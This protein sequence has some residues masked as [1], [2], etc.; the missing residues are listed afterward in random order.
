LII[1]ARLLSMEA[2]N[3]VLE[4]D[5]PESKETAAARIRGADGV[6]LIQSFFGNALQITFFHP[7]GKDSEGTASAETRAFQTAN[8]N[9][10]TRWKVN[11]PRCDH[12]P[13]ELDWRIIGL[14]LRNA[15]RRFPEMA[16]DLKVSTRTVKRRVNLMMGSSAFFVQPEL[17]FKK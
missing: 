16:A 4:F 3:L 14:M 9:V 10:V 13:K 6:V 11:L 17:D 8:A 15:E 2:S 5:D 12:K 7:G 1:N